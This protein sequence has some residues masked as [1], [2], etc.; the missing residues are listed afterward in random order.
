MDD[1]NTDKKAKGT[2]IYVIKRCIIFDNYAECLKKGKKILR[3]QQTFKS[4]GHDVYTE[5]INKVALLH[6]D[7]KRLISY[8]GITTYPH[9]IGVG[10]LCKQ[11]LLSKVKIVY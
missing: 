7:D 9:G 1:Y 2:K 10:L 3:S 4:D 11:E 5:E 6:D 8:Y